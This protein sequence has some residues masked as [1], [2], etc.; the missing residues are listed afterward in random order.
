MTDSIYFEDFYIESNFL[1]GITRAGEKMKFT[2]S[3]RALL[4]LL[5]S[6]PGQILSRSQLLNTIGTDDSE[7]TDRNIDYLI[8]RLRKKLKD[9]KKNAKYIGTQYGEGYLWLA[10]PLSKDEYQSGTP[11]FLHIRPAHGLTLLQ[12]HKPNATW[13]LSQLVTGLKAAFDPSNRPSNRIVDN[14]AQDPNTA[15]E[16]DQGV[17]I[18]EPSFI[19]IKSELHCAITV[20]DGRTKNII[21]ADRITLPIQPP[22][23]QD[24]PD[25]K[26]HAQIIKDKIWQYL[27]YQDNV[28]HTA[29]DV[30]LAFRLDDATALFH[31][32]Y[33]GLKKVEGLLRETLQK[34]PE[35][36]C[37]KILL[38]TLIH[39]TL[40]DESHDISDTRA[41]ENEMETLLLDALP[42]VQNQPLF[43]LAVA[44]LLFFIGRGHAHLAEEIAKE[45]LHN[46]TTYAATFAVNGQMRIYLGD[47]EDGLDLLTQSLELS[48]KGTQFQI[49][50]HVL[51]CAGF[52]A[53]ERWDDSQKELALMLSSIPQDQFRRTSTSPQ[54]SLALMLTPGDNRPASPP[55]MAMLAKMTPETAEGYLKRSHYTVVRLFRQQKH[56]SNLLRGSLKLLTERFGPGIV[57]DVV[58]E[59]VPELCAE[60]GAD[61]PPVRA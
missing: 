19:A 53:A 17:F 5:L 22:L 52:M 45:A 3:E 7:T 51:R 56:R 16:K 1:F 43:Y 31:P 49:F 38:A 54:L 46:E 4:T 15:A 6:K 41:E 47:I 61:R 27:T 25:I 34:Y 36:H 12:H 35:D 55:I 11:I 28:P 44:K 20:R 58:R 59:S 40:L 57:P 10:N 13:C 26:G 37:S 48:E 33:E 42:H 2:R 29:R 60:L 14:S 23:E 50:L 39:T 8:S 32:G 30:P 21:M 24:S 18:L 9:P